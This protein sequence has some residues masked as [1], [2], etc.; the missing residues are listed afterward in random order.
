M[1]ESIGLRFFSCINVGISS[2]KFPSESCPFCI[3]LVLVCLIFTCIHFKVFSHFPCDF[4]FF[5]P[6]VKNMWFCFH[7]PTNFSVCLFLPASSLSPL[8]L[9]KRFVWFQS[10]NLLQLIL[11]PDLPSV[12]KSVPRGPERDVCSAIVWA[13]RSVCVC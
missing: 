11:C 8:W 10:S 7:T 5:D 3:L 6:L 2:C 9:E 1:N 12:L 13:G 4:F